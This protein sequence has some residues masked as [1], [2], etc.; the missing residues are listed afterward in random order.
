[1][2]RKVFK[3]ILALTMLLSTVFTNLLFV[4]A[5]NPATN[6]FDKGT[7][8]TSTASN[9][10][11]FNDSSKVNDGII[12]EESRWNSGVSNGEEKEYY[13]ITHFNNNPAPT[14]NKE[15]VKTVVVN[16]Y[17]KNFDY[18]LVKLRTDSGWQ[19]NDTAC[20]VYTDQSQSQTQ[21]L[22]TVERGVYRDVITFKQ[23][24]D[25]NKLSIVVPESAYKTEA[26][27]VFGQSITNMSDISITEY[28]LYD[29]GTIP[30]PTVAE[31]AYELELGSWTVETTEEKLKL[32]EGAAL[33]GHQIT[34]FN[35]SNPDVIDNDGNITTPKNNLKIKL[36]INLSDGTTTV[37]SREFI[38]DVKGTSGKDEVNTRVNYAR[39][40]E[41]VASATSEEMLPN[42]A[43]RSAA[44]AIDG[45]I[46]N[47]HRWASANNADQVPLPKEALTI[48]LG[49]SKEVEEIEL[50]W[51][52]PNI[53]S[54]KVEVSSD[55]NEW[56]EVYSTTEKLT[57]TTLVTKIVLPKPQ[58]VQ[59][60]KVSS[61]NYDSTKPDGTSGGFTAVSL[62]EVKIFDKKYSSGIIE[63]SDLAS[64]KDY[65][66]A[67]STTSG[68]IGLGQDRLNFATVSGYDVEVCADY[69][70]VIGQDGSIH[71]PLTDQTIKFLY[72]ISDD[73]GKS[74]SSEY[75]VLVKGQYEDEGINEKPKVIPELAQWHGTTGEFKMSKTSQII[76]SD[77][78]LLNSVTEFKNDLKEMQGV[79]HEIVKASKGQTGDFI[80]KMVSD[81]TGLGEEGYEM[82]VTDQVIIRA[83]APT[84]AY[85]GTRSILQILQQTNDTINKGLARDYPKYQVRGFMFDVARR[86]FSLE[87]IK[88]VAKAM[89]WYK[90]NDYQIHL[91]DNYAKMEKHLPQ[92]DWNST[93]F[94][95][96]ENI[97]DEVYSAFRLESNE[98]GLT[99]TDQSYSKAE[100]GELIDSSKNIGLN[101]VP[102]FDVP[103]HSLS[104]LKNNRD[105]YYQGAI[106]ADPWGTVV[107]S[108][109]RI[110]MFDLDNPNA[111][112]Y[113]KNLFSEYIDDGTFRD[114]VIHV[115]ADEYYGSKDSYR[116]YVD[117]ILEYI[118]EDKGRTARIWGSLTAKNGNSPIYNKNVQ[119]NI[120]NYDW[121]HP[122]DMIKQ[123]FDIINTND[124]ELYIVPGGNWYH[125]YLNNEY[126]YNI[127]EPNRF[128]NGASQY[129]EMEVIPAGN[130]QMIGACFAVWNDATDLSANGIN[131]YEVSKRI[132]S[133]LPAVA[134]KMWGDGKDLNFTE[135]EQLSNQVKDIPGVNLLYEV[136]SKTD[137]VVDYDFNNSSLIDNSSNGY[138]ITGTVVNSELSNNC[139]T[140]KGGRSYLETGLSDLGPT[141]HLKISVNRAENSDDS[142]QILLESDQGTI[143]AVQKQTGKVGY[144]RAGYDYSFN[145]ILP[146]GQWV[147]LEITCDDK[148]VKLY[149]NGD[150]VDT[151]N[152]MQ[153]RTTGKDPYKTNQAIHDT[154]KVRFE[155][156]PTLVLPLARI[157]SQDKA[158]IGSID[159]LKV[160]NKTVSDIDYQ[161]LLEKINNLVESQYTEESWQ[162]LQ[163]A[164]RDNQ[165]TVNEN[166]TQKEIDTATLNIQTAL[167]GLIRI[168]EVET[169]KQF[170]Q[171]AIEVAD[172]VSEAELGKVVPAVV[173]EFKAALAEAKIIYADATAAQEQVDA[174]AMRLAK[175]M[176]M[177][178]FIKGDKTALGEL[179]NEIKGLQESDYTVES[180]QKLQT[181]LAKAEVLMQDENA[182][183]Y[184]VEEMKRELKEA[185]DQ[186]EEVSKINKEWLQAIVDK[187]MELEEEKYT[188]ESWQA[189]QPLLDQATKVLKDANAT[190]VQIDKAKEDLIR[191]YLE[192]RLKPNKELLEELINKADQLNK[193]SYN[194]V[195]WTRF[196][197]A[198]M[199]AKIVLRDSNASE[200]E[201]IAAL[202]KLDISI[203]ELVV[204]EFVGKVNNTKE[205]VDTGDVAS[206]TSIIGLAGSLGILRCL[207]K[208]KKA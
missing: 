104:F 193:A 178:S 187:V 190:Q 4:N 79:D 139:L 163:Q 208:K 62:L 2:Q 51:Q 93:D 9:I 102:E 147:D 76:Y 179:I 6:L 115:G 23:P 20:K 80:F 50:H 107:P 207:K 15:R 3:G 81:K 156:Y 142:E 119:M 16:W 164:M 74:E 61:D 98:S 63:I 136:D 188:V 13:F 31:T 126:I 35:S 21:N 52:R 195:S 64:A 42:G 134:A 137:K 128:V 45:I 37:T 112:T 96:F 118:S 46:D 67:N 92:S 68:I 176:H 191:G 39:Q 165:I 59:S 105:L 149:V 160:Y 88:Q 75:T 138:D 100:F 131:E 11:G 148:A 194:E 22:Y 169:N 153:T 199:E 144:S 130:E 122:S 114:S 143:K 196:Q 8:T 34:S 157:G 66:V 150:L 113:I 86:P 110:A 58:E 135:F 36:S 99:S 84:G 73:E 33:N 132:L 5:E 116:R 170:L 177:L 94:S 173:T 14:T 41:T 56:Q 90:L 54:F 95:K 101:I 18:Y 201:V 175:A 44:L 192:L 89:S 12:S 181:V 71:R 185:Y 78:S 72:K 120:W 146:I 32:P 124:A 189:M 47:D 159:N 154:S 202:Q 106:E 49:A 7:T 123:G 168:G 48:D 87:M 57:A 197:K 111:V 43:T 27:N 38:V 82:E 60:V 28:A 174:S 171:I 172:K 70:Q 97:M 151:K 108:A 167:D 103:G 166:T 205:A 91:N 53:I 17:A 19:S 25:A 133:A 183:E 65:V 161:E 140:L 125:D 184:E 186:L 200:I 162:A 26:I 69:E 10:E 121:A 198:L 55:N 29:E 141:N 145:Y 129:T 1:M 158:F 180:W 182:L 152:I 109:D 85:Y 83:A 155:D 40:K 204:K 203:K 24:I 206:F 127:F 30:A 117:D 77:D